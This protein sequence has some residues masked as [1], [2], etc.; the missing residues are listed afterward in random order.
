M[1]IRI[2]YCENCDW[3]RFPKDAVWVGVCKRCK[4][5]SGHVAEIE[6][7]EVSNGDKKITA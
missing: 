6:F 3:Q 5:G 2:V 1:K 7:E 4:K